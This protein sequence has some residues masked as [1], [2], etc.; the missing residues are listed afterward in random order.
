MAGDKSVQ[1]TGDISVHWTKY[2][3]GPW[4]GDKA[5]HWVGDKGGYWAGD[6]GGYWAADILKDDV[7]L[8]GQNFSLRILRKKKYK[9]LTKKYIIC[10]KHE[11]NNSKRD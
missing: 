4:A 2:K 3:G 7:F 11:E 5:G 10:V 1:W 8:R 6:K 9:N